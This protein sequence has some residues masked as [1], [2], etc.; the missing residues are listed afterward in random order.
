MRM[1]CRRRSLM[2]NESWILLM[3]TVSNY[4]VD[5]E[6]YEP[7]EFNPLVSD[8][9]INFPI[10]KLVGPNSEYIIVMENLMDTIGEVYNPIYIIPRSNINTDDLSSVAIGFKLHKDD[11]YMSY[12]TTVESAGID[13]HNIYMSPNLIGIS[14]N[15]W[16]RDCFYINDGSSVPLIA[17]TCDSYDYTGSD[18]G[19]GDTPCEH[20]YQLYSKGYALCAACGFDNGTLYQYRCEYCDQEYYVPSYCR[21]CGNNIL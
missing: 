11:N 10:S 15:V 8:V 1:N 18:G 20:N 6:L 13:Y 5:N 16:G 9:Y 19:G 3:S 17:F 12:S 14:S 21:N 4:Y 2:V 7:G